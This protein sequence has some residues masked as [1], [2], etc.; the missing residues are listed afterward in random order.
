ME[1]KEYVASVLEYDDVKESLMCER[2]FGR[3]QGR[4][5]GR[6]EG[7]RQLIK[8]LLANG[9]DISTISKATGLD[10]TEIRNLIRG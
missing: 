3:E 8:S 4:E 1:K 10:E 6:I 7:Q 5:E 9:L 2:E